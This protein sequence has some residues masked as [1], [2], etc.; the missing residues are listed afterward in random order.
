MGPPLFL[1]YML[2]IGSIFSKHGTL[3][4][5]YA[6]DMQIYVP[7]KKEC[8]FLEHFLACLKKLITWLAVN[9]LHLNESKTK[10]IVFAPSNASGSTNIDLGSLSIYGKSMV[11]NL[12][13]IFDDALRFDKQING[14]VRSGFFQLR[15][16]AKIKLFLSFCDF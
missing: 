12:G 11:R 3:F 9:F 15:T 2:P 14:V 1:S 10:I 5:C 7:V 6:D 8:N 13:V 4:H 16:L